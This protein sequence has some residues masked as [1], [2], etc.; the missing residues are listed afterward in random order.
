MMDA[1]LAPYGSTFLLTRQHLLDAKTHFVVKKR[2]N[3]DARRG[4][5]SKT[6]AS[7]TM[8]WLKPQAKNKCFLDCIFA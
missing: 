4:T 3:G 1:V 6:A 2:V 8:S 5:S 7:A